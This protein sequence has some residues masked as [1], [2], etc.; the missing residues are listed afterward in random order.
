[1]V[2]TLFLFDTVK[3]HFSKSYSSNISPA[4]IFFS[5]L[6]LSLSRSKW[7]TKI[8]EKCNL[9][10]LLSILLHLGQM[11]VRYNGYMTHG[12]NVPLSS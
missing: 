4:W 5:L 3:K 8:C 2:S 1:M 12:W 6:P 7:L 10:S 9:T 11:V